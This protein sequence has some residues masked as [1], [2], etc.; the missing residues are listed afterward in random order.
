METAQANRFTFEFLCALCLAAEDA[1]LNKPFLAKG[2]V[3][4]DEH[5]PGFL[6]S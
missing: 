2:R 6:V 5:R 1:G 4:V 3:K